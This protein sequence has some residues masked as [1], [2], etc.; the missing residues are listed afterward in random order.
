MMKTIERVSCVNEKCDKDCLI[1]S[2]AYRINDDGEYACSKQCEQEY[3]TNKK[4]FFGTVI[5]DNKKLANYFGVSYEEEKP[6]IE[7]DKKLE[8]MKLAPLKKR[9]LRKRNS[10]LF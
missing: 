3:I 4:H 9:S 8:V 1:V 6:A 2:G 10:G 7:N 5:Y